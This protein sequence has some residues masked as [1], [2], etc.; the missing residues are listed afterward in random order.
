MAGLF[1]KDVARGPVWGGGTSPKGLIFSK[2]I[3]GFF[4]AFSPK[5]RGGGYRFPVLP[6]S[7]V[8]AFP[9]QLQLEII[10]NRFYVCR[11]SKLNIRFVI[12]I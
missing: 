11:L 12:L 1:H 2:N 5:E 3:L 6:Y 8:L 4:R 10:N 7:Y 9:L